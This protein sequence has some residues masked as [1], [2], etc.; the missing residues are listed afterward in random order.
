MISS[1][2]HLFMCMLAIQSTISYRNY[3]F[4]K[5]LGSLNISSLTRSQIFLIIAHNIFEAMCVFNPENIK[6]SVLRNIKLFT[7]LT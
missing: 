7:I 2:E 4:S 1:V 6:L 3:F 5:R